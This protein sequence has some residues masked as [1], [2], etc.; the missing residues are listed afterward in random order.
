V[1]LPPAG[2]VDVVLP[3]LADTGR[4]GALRLLAADGSPWGGLDWI[5]RPRVE[6]ELQSGRARVTGVP[7]G[8]WTV[9][10]TTPDGE[11]RTAT[12]TTAPGTVS[13]VRFD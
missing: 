5:G 3:A 13:E 1:T 4:Y 6:W 7:P 12:V 11:R 10:V 9:E 2:I 8:S